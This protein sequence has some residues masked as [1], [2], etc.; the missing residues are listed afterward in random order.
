[1]IVKELINP[2]SIVIIGASNNIEKPGGKITQNILDGAYNGKLYAVNPKEK[3]VQ[4]IECF[5]K[6][7][8]LPDVELAILAIAANYVPS[9]IEELARDKGT[10]AFIVLSAGFSEIGP[11]GKKL[12]NQILDI[13]NKYKVTLI[14]PNCI[15]VIT[16]RYK[17]VFAGPIPKLDPKGCDCVSASG[18][19][20]VFILEVAIPRG[21]TFSNIFSVG[22]SI[23][24]GVE[25][26]IEYWDV[27]FDPDKS[28]RIKLIYTE[29]IAKPEKFLKHCTSLIK[30]GCKIAAIKAG[31]TEAGS[32]AV[33][34]HTGALAGSDT[35]VSALFNKAG[36]VRCHS[37]V[38]LVYV[39]GVFAHKELKG[40][41][42][43]V[44]THAG[45]PGVML[46]DTLSRGG[47]KVP[48]IKG[49]AADELL[50]KLNFG[51]SVSNP[52]DFLATGT[53]EQLGT[54][55]DYVDHEFHNIDAS[56]V[57]FG[58]T[59]MFDVTGVYDVLH[60]KMNTCRKPIYPVLPSVVQAAK[61]VNHFLSLG[62]INFTD[63]VSLGRALCK[64]HFTPKPFPDPIL[65]QIDKNSVRWIIENSPKGYL[66]PEKIQGL[67]DASGIAR[68]KE[69][70]AYN[71]EEAVESAKLI[72]FPVA[73]K[74]IG[75]IHKS[76][77]GGVRLNVKS[78]SEV[79]SAFY[80][81]MAIEGATGV[82]IQQM[83]KGNELFIGAKKEPDFGHIIL[84]GLGGIFIEVFKDITYGLAPVSYEEALFMI[85][86]I[87]AYGIIKGVRGREGVNEDLLADRI[88]RLSAL[89]QAAP[90]ISELDFN[91]MLGGKDFVTVVDSRIKII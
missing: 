58:T 91:P 57:V 20:M 22:N 75:P 72:G 54:I 31:T 24:I 82:I 30:K 7:S 66:S 32:R 80:E 34:S 14:G 85:R 29:K 12:E 1:M 42:I 19:T 37:R 86:N 15:G 79:E 84:F 17:G 89:L 68:A 76:D 28:S 27:T 67:L 53:A 71:I 59:G 50:S 44:I 38:E 62:R 56:A 35:A 10:K 49:Y 33:S 77:V 87:K 2:E 55:L 21:L 46:T 74:V 8:D 26:V 81:L 48:Q 36:I 40:D 4:G 69:D 39:A 3:T 13:V 78:K 43:A 64:V 60:E 90:E 47:L 25:E 63:E 88:V 18:A 83:L 9:T 70:L 5:N 6:V 45:G 23:Q 51:S 11:E 52:I 73:M 65:P 16:N 61:A 41:R